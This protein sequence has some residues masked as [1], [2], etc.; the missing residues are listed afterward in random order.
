MSTTLSPRCT[1]A[2]LALCLSACA[3]TA[4]QPEAAFGRSVRATLAS[5]IAHP[6]AVRNTN[7]VNG[8]DGAAALQAQQKY[9]KSFTKESVDGNAP[10][11]KGR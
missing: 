6:E 10:L 7:P 2:L 9:E 8:I 3:S 4:R 5:Q 1:A 11:V